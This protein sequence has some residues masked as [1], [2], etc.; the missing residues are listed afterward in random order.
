V[1]QE[2]KD[3]SG[4][5]GIGIVEKRKQTFSTHKIGRTVTSTKKP[6]AKY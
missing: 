2:K 5:H 6:L 1:K 4:E 3:K